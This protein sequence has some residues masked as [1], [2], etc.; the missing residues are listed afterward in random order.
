MVRT[1]AV[2]AGCAATLFLL[3]TACAD[4]HA[5]ENRQDALAHAGGGAD[6]GSALASALD[7]GTGP[8]VELSMEQIGQPVSAL[9]ERFLFPEGPVWS[10]AQ[11]AL[12]FTDISGDAIYRLKLPD[13]LDLLI[14]P[15]GQPDGLAL[16]PD[17]SMWVAG[18]GARD[19]WKLVD[20][21]RVDVVDRYEG[22]RF[23][24]PDD[25]I[26]RSD[27]VAYF[28]DPTFGI[29]GTIGLPRQDRE[30]DF[31]GLYRIDAKGDLHLEDMSI[32]GPNGV[33]LS[34]DEKTLFVSSTTRGS[35]FAYD[36]KPDGSLSAPPRVW[37]G[38][39]TGAD[40]FCVDER[41][42]L[43]V[44]TFLGIAIVNA[45]GVTI[46]S[47][48]VTGLASNVAFG[49]P[50]RKTLFITT[51]ALSSRSS[52]PTGQLLRIDNMPIAG[53][54]PRWLQPAR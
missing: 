5:V 51:R 9:T 29:D 2:G 34:P 19:V 38:K 33:R 42:N 16:A 48:T 1:A 31:E 52:M 11:D 47:I 14:Q 40:S 25:V 18:F 4:S 30:L 21:E 20:G 41:G 37:N 39:L 35:V 13:T 44:A 15:A 27:G 10:A 28:T 36:I 6:N 17:G 54:A 50:D 46:G 32:P 49:G 8:T 7:A 22:K 23:N 45:Q 3:V 53:L 12:Y 26:V 24:S 43:Y